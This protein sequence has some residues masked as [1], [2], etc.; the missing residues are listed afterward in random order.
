MSQ[1]RGVLLVISTPNLFAGSVR[2]SKQHASAVI[3]LVEGEGLHLANLFACFTNVDHLHRDKG[4]KTAGVADRGRVKATRSSPSAFHFGASRLMSAGC[5]CWT[6]AHS[7][8]KSDMDNGAIGIMTLTERI[9]IKVG[10]NDDG[11]FRTVF[12]N[13]L[14][15]ARCHEHVRGLRCHSDE[16]K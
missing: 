15:C 14:E 3:R 6:L 5:A 1:P 9:S 16:R 12:A 13:V 7:I 8:L 10:D 2:C 4:V 11:K